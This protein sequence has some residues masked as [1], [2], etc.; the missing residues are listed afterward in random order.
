MRPGTTTAT[1]VAGEKLG[2]VANAAVT[3]FV[4]QEETLK[5]AHSLLTCYQGPVSFYMAR[6]PDSADIN[7]WDGAGQ[8]WVK[9]GVIDAVRTGSSWE[10]PAYSE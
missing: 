6:V 9:V 3:H 2:F 7:T 8:V 4:R 5:Q 10:W 1:V